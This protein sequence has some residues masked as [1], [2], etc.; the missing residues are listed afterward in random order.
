MAICT[1]EEQI[2]TINIPLLIFRAKNLAGRKEGR[3]GGWK[4]GKAG[5]R[6]AYSNQKWKTISMAIEKWNID[7]MFEWGRLALDEG[8]R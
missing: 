6:I 8:L 4:E 2:N 3:K 5:L 7:R 1:T